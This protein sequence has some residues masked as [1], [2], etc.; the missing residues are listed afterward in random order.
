MCP[1]TLA[2]QQSLEVISQILQEFEQNTGLRTNFEKSCIFRL[3]RCKETNFKPELSKKFKWANSGILALGVLLDDTAKSYEQIFIK[4]ESVLNCWAK[5]SMSLIG[6]ITIVNSLIASLFVYQMQV[7]L[8][9]EDKLL[10]KFNR[11]ITNFIWNERKPKI[12]LDILQQ[13][14]NELG[15]RLVNLKSRDD[16]LKIAWIKR[17]IELPLNNTLL[18]LTKNFLAT[19]IIFSEFWRLN[20]RESH[21][22]YVCNAN[23]FWLSLIQAWSRFNYHDPQDIQDILNQ[24]IWGNSHITIR[25]KPVFYKSFIEKGVLTMLDIVDENTSKLYVYDKYS[26]LYGPVNFL[27]FHSIIHA[28]P[29]LWK[30]CIAQLTPQ[31]LDESYLMPIDEIAQLQQISRKVYEKF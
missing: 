11:L 9:M 3:G 24:C 21:I 27:E 1:F 29:K 17:I 22:K 14:K 31:I 13:L 12:K 8:S 26:Q 25:K 16:A 7:L 23:G 4:V 18:L 28:I 19:K 5:R 6:K 15:L 30:N 2:D 20:F 10:D